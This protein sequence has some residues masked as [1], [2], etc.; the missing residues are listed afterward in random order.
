M[1]KLSFQFATYKFSTATNRF[2]VEWEFIGKAEINGKMYNTA[3][4]VKVYN[5]KNNTIENWT[6]G[7]PPSQT[8][9]KQ[10]INEIITGSTFN[11]KTPIK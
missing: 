7:Y 5:D 2:T 4:K 9:S 1:A 3:Y 6:V 10:F 8:A 11:L